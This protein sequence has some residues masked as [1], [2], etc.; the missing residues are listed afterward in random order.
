[1]S[2]QLLCEWTED[3]TFKP[4]AR[5]SKHCDEMFVVGE[6][7]YVTPEM[8]RD[9]RSH[10]HFMAQVK[11]D[12][13]NLPEDIAEQFAS[14]EHLR[15]WALCK[16]GFCTE[17]RQV[18]TRDRD[19]VLAAAFAAASSE[20]AIVSVNGNIVTTWKPESQ[21]VN[22]MGAERFKQ[23]KRAV[24]DYLASL[25]GVTPAQVAEVAERSAA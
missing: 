1:M 14:P 3:G 11:T 7:Y 13:E 15:K 23:S 25:I 22:S 9:M 4:L 24:L 12:W 21:R 20:Y 10:R 18:F 5:H 6:K 17:T 19:A 16:T 2:E 8:P